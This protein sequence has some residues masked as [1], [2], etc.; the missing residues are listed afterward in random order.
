[1]LRKYAVLFVLILSAP[2][3]FADSTIH[4]KI[5]A[6]VD[7]EKHFLEASDQIT[8][9][10][11]QA[12]SLMHFILNSNL[13]VT[14]ETP[15]VVVALDQ[16]G[17]KAEDFGMDREDFAASGDFKQNKY[18]L[19]FKEGSTKDVT[20]TLKFSGVINYPITQVGEEYARGFSQTPGIIDAKGVY[21]GGSTYWVPWFNNAWI[22]FNLTTTMSDPWEVVS[23]GKRTVHEIRNGVRVST[24]D[25][26][27][28]MEEIYLIAAR[29][30]EYA[31]SAG[32][33]DVM[34][35][36]RTPRRNPCEQVP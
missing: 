16:T 31:L 5:T 19:T 8:I 6:K 28:P 21:L 13:K 18:S 14:S 34:A 11:T 22:S 9:P 2:L 17:V 4:H 24:W 15:G 27:E 10:A 25:S 33:T 35:F 32:A 3:L 36:L 30:K 23:Q 1:M 20:F 29:F 12:K 7:P 26:P